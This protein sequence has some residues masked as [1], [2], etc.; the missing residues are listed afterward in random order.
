MDGGK[1]YYHFGDPTMPQNNFHGELVIRRCTHFI[2]SKNER[3]KKNVEIGLDLCWIHLI[4]DKSL[5]LKPSSILGAG[6]GLFAHDPNKTPNAVIFKA[7]TVI[8]QY[9]GDVIDNGEL[10]RRYGEKSPQYTVKLSGSF[11]DRAN[12]IY[13]DA[14]LERGIGSMVNHTPFNRR[15]NAYLKIHDYRMVLKAKRD[16]KNNR[17]ILTTY[18]ENFVFDEPNIKSVTNHN[19]KKF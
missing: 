12:V 13:E 19:K 1:K 8:C 5:R 16:I 18:G 15:I 3:C 4:Q 10:I 2:D 17:E 14:A 9:D 7:N 6:L 11:Q